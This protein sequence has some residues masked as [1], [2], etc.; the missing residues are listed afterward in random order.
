MFDL[1]CCISAVEQIELV[2]RLFSHIGHYRVLS[3]VPCAIHRSFLVIYF[4]Y[5]CSF[6][7]SCSILCDSVDCSNAGFPVFPYFPEFA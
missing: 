1:Q 6:A 7:K 5:C 4:I 3:R 2:F